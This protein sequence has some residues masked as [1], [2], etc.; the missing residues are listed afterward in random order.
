MLKDLTW[1]GE[2]GHQRRQDHVQRRFLKAVKTLAEVRR[3]LG[4]NIQVN[5]AEKQINVM[6]PG[7]SEGVPEETAKA[8]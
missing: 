1:T 2:E 8:V 3:L 6:A 7:R 4:P 5:I